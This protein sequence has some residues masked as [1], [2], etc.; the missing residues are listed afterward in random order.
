MGSLFDGSGGFPLAGKINGIKPVWA[1]EVEPFPIKVTRARFPEMKHLGNISKLNGADIPPVDII[2]GGSPCQGL[3]LGGY[4]E[5]LED[6]RSCLFYEQIRVVKEMRGATN[7]QYPKYM[8]W[9][10]VTG[11]LSSHEGRDFHEVLKEI[12]K[13]KDPEANV[14][15]PE[16]G[17]WEPAGSIV[18]DG[19]S[20]CW[21]VL[22]AQ[23]WGVPQRRQ[24]IFLVAAFDE[25]CAEKILFESES[26]FR[27]SS[28]DFR[29]WEK[30]P[31]DS[32]RC[33]EEAGWTNVLISNHS[34]DS[35]YKLMEVSEMLNAQMGTGGNNTP[36]TMK[37]RS[38]KPGG[39]KGALITENKIGTLSTLQ[40]ITLFEPVDNPIYTTSIQNHH[41]KASENLV[42]TLVAIDYKDPPT[43]TYHEDNAKTYEVE[44][45]TTTYIVRR[46]MPEECARLQGFPDGWCDG[47]E[48]E[49]PSE[50]DLVF[51]RNV[52]DEHSEING[53]KK[54]SDKQIIKW[55]KTKCTDSAAYK[56][57]GNGVALPCVD[58]VMCSIAEHE[59]QKSEEEI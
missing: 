11:A 47:L 23:Y 38:G 20:I 59:R 41:T 54:K 22:D 30:T 18:G 24:R 29:T 43:V 4:R 33:S 27:N 31:E 36:F 50:E 28:A 35:R 49:E 16:K 13:I 10:N 42:E 58:Y 52:F 17:K 25:E 57:W 46:I 2:C 1:S 53:V 37:I 56:M 15:F 44:E 3:S 9:E 14:P 32:R 19:Y 55:L 40:D 48:T 34:Q 12:S 21:R 39:G 6:K 51:W 7:G 8:V 26:V 45:D 5:G